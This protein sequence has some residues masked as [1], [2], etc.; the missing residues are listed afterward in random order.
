MGVPL[1]LLFRCVVSLYDHV[2]PCNWA[3]CIITRT[4]AN[5]GLAAATA[6]QGIG[7]CPSNGHACFEIKTQVRQCWLQPTA[8]S[9]SLRRRAW[10]HNGATWTA[11]GRDEQP[12][13]MAQHDKMSQTQQSNTYTSDVQLRLYVHTVAASQ[14]FAATVPC[15]LTQHNGQEAFHCMTRLNDH[16]ACSS[17]YRQR[18]CAHELV[19]VLLAQLQQQD[20]RAVATTASRLL[21]GFIR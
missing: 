19:P 16:N 2:W 17:D 18:R 21:H 3:V 4:R 8:S 5:I 14:R 12:G 6:S 10:S 13:F 1:M 20:S 15:I 9:L 7:A 11:Q